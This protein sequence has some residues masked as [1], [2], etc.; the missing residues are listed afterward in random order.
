[1]NRK[2]ITTL[3]ALSSLFLAGCAT[4]VVVSSGQNVDELRTKWL[5]LEAQY[6]KPNQGFRDTFRDSL[7]EL[8]YKQGELD[9]LQ[10]P[11]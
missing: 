11:K 10:V 1:M 2:R 3:L 4:P 5:A 8:V 9:K 7:N 6:G